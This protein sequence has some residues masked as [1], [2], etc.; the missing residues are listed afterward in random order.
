[1]T[2]NP[3]V[4]KRLVAVC[5]KGGTGKTAFTAM[6]TRALLESSQAGKLLLIDA[7]PALGLP[8][9]LGVKVK[10]TMGQIREDIIKTAR[11]G[12]QSEKTQIADRLDYMILEALIGDAGLCPAGHGAHRD[13]GMLL[14]GQRPPARRDRDTIQ[15]L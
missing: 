5:G 4:T 8:N 9:A 13:P 7:D 11:S 6:M 3:K 12:D 1:M 2:D 14:S 15:E 10:R